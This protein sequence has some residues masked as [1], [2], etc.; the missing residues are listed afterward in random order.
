[1]QAMIELCKARGLMLVLAI[2]EYPRMD[3]KL[4]LNALL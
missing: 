3:V 2:L 1:M 4:S